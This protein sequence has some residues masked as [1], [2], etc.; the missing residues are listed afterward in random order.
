MT[1]M[2]SMSHFFTLEAT[3]SIN[4]HMRL[5]LSSKSRVSRLIPKYALSGAWAGGLLQELFSGSVSLRGPH[6]LRLATELTK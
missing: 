6:N 5:S 3:K 4:R 1:P 2:G